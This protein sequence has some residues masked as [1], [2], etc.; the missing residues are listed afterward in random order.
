MLVCCVSSSCDSGR[1][2]WACFN[3]CTGSGTVRSQC[4]SGV[5]I[6]WLCQGGGAAFQGL[7]A[8]GP[9]LAVLAEFAEPVAASC[10]SPLV[11]P[12]LLAPW[13]AGAWDAP[14]WS[15][16]HFSSS[17]GSKGC[18]ARRIV[19]T[20]LS[21]VINPF[22]VILINNSI[23]SVLLRPR[24]LFSSDSSVSPSSP[25]GCWFPR[26][27]AG[28]SESFLSRAMTGFLWQV[29]FWLKTAVILRALPPAG[30]PREVAGRACA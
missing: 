24:F 4:G 14:A 6:G 13:S 22:V 29:V 23:N 25:P 1:N 10:L 2:C 30:R 16:L 20:R 15:R 21:I 9:A 12:R 11:L 18:N 3:L 27:L 17:R 5:G 8:L 19:E 28:S 7:R 26:L